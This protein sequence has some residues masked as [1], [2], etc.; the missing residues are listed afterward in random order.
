MRPWQIRTVGRSDLELV[1]RHRE[2]M[3]LAAGRAPDVV[4]KMREPFREWLRRQMERGLYFGCVAER[5]GRIAG[6]VGLI[7]LDWPPHPF[8]PEQARRGYVLNVFVEPEF[9]GAGCARALM[10][11]TEA[12]MRRRGIA[13]ASLHATDAGRPLYEGMGW[14][15]TNEMAKRP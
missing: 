8:H 15:G 5:E 9:R 13:Y 11:A 14:V 6:G 10:D 3:F 12:E 1:C 4:A 2:E 7:E